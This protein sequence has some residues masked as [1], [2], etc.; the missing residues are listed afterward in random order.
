MT[1][2]STRVKDVRVTYAT[3]LPSTTNFEVY[4][5]MDFA[6]HFNEGQDT[7]VWLYFPT[8]T[9]TYDIMGMAVITHSQ[10][11]SFFS[12]QSHITTV[13]LLKLLYSSDVDL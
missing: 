9:N 7:T 6:L 8:S 4:H 10:S 5:M 1:Q 13:T 3:S 2:D 12:T 11:L